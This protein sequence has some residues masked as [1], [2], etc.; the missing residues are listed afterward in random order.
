M[1]TTGTLARAFMV[2]A[3]SFDVKMTSHGVDVAVATS[4][5]STSTSTLLALATLL[6]FI[7]SNNELPT[8]KPQ[9][10]NMCIFFNQDL[11]LSLYMIK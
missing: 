5:V 7:L 11:P 8:P 1:T 2:S 4:P 6:I 9:T 10:A 3:N